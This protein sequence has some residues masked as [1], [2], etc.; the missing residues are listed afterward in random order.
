MIRGYDDIKA[1]AGAIGCPVDKLIALSPANDPFYAGLPNRAE[2]GEWFAEIWEEFGFGDGVHLRRIHYVLISQRQHVRKPDGEPYLNTTADWK[3]LGTASLAARYLKLVPAEAFVDRRNPDPLIFA[4]RRIG[5]TS[6][7]ILYDDCR[8]FTDLPEELDTPQ[9]YLSGFD[10]EQDYLVEVWIEKST[11]QDILLPLAQRLGFNLITGVGEMSET[12]ARNVVG[13]AA[14]SGKP[15]RILYVSDFDPKGR[16][17][18]VSLARK[19]EYTLRGAELDLDIT[20]QPIV[21]TP[22]QCD[23]Y[24]LPRAPIEKRGNGHADRFE[25]KFGSGATELDALEALH[26]GELAKVVEQEVSRYLDPTLSHRV[27]IKRLP[28][29]RSLKGITEDV[30]GQYAEAIYEIENRYQQIRNDASELESDADQLWSQISSDLQEE[31]PSITTAD[32]PSPRDADPPAEPLFDSTR[33][34]I[35]QIDSYRAWQEGAP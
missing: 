32:I 14:D 26:P 13:R 11:Q 24:S 33:E 29:D 21:L 34:Y 8:L 28:L 25:E 12:A 3:F 19:I 23:H 2:K 35:E 22:D 5:G 9:L 16:E 20:L 27:S 1:L 18:P 7:A 31:A 6:V 17:M 4:R 30:H 15:T 10:P